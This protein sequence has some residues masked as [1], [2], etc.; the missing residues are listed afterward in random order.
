[1]HLLVLQ[2]FE[3]LTLIN[4]E[5]LTVAFENISKIEAKENKHKLELLTHY[6]LLKLE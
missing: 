6:I 1:M 2:F 5:S 3:I 4:K